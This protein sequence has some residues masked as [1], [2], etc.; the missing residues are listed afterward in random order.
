MFALTDVKGKRS[1]G[2][3]GQLIVPGFLAVDG[4]RQKLN[5]LKSELP[6]PP[7]VEIGIREEQMGVA[8]IPSIPKG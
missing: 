5:V 7:W 3:N 4:G 1:E 8:A 2:V 6:T